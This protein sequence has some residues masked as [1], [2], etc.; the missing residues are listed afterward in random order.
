[1]TFGYA[2]NWGART[3]LTIEDGPENHRTFGIGVKDSNT[4]SYV[5]VLKTDAPQLA[6]AILEAAGYTKSFLGGPTAGAAVSALH[7]LVAQS[8]VS[9]LVQDIEKRLRG[10]TIS[11]ED[12]HHLMLAIKARTRD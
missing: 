1:M 3:C 10:A 2:D 8:R 7:D 5:D 6:L 11:T 4:T 9:P 12:A